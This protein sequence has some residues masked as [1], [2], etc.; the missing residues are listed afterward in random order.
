MLERLVSSK[1]ARAILLE[2]YNDL[3]VYVEDTS[4]GYRKIYKELLNK[5]FDGQ[6]TIQ[7][8]LPIG[9]RNQVIQECY[10]NQIPNGRKK[11]FI[12]DGDLYLLNNTN[13]INLN[14]LYVLPRY[15]IENYLLDETAIV[16]VYYEEDPSLEK[17]QIEV[18]LDFK[19]W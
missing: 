1:S 13:I 7:H 14:G 9:D 3:D 12:V 15:C 2:D 17:N 11:I 18:G 5:V 10:K 4:D 8:I 19:N 16:E 6:L